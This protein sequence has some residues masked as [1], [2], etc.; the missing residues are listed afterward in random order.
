MTTE[1]TYGN[2]YNAFQR[3]LYMAFDLGQSEWKLGFTIGFGQKPR[4][5]TIAARDLN[6]LQAEIRAAKKRFG[7]AEDT[8]VLSC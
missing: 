7:L 5:R 1:T 4:L 8:P 2:E 3:H 6:A